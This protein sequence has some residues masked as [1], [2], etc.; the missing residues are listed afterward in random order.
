[1]RHTLTLATLG[2]A[3][4]LPLA[5][6]EIPF[7]DQWREQ[8]F[9][10]QPANEYAL[11]GDTLGVSSEGTVS[12]V[13]RRTPEVPDATGAS[14][15]WTVTEGVPATDL[16][17]K[18]GD[19]RNLALYFVF[20]DDATAEAL[21]GASLRRLLGAE[22]ARILVYVRGGDVAPGTMQDSPYLGERGKT[23]VLAETGT[24]SQSERVDFDADLQ[25][26]FGTRPPRLLG[27]A[28]S[29]D[30]DDTDSV[31]DATISG[32]SLE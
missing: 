3:F 27:V 8:T 10:F 23:I 6:A 17:Q 2:A 1:M 4:A 29:A 32:L 26:A 5:A 13:Y 31:I 28:V 24:G 12:L 15:S 19:D 30:S 21:Q 9:P 20:A 14:W 16:A 25:E 22:A 7:D 18:G 11:N